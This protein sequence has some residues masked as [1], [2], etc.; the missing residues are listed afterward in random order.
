M[1]VS[2]QA[3]RPGGGVPPRRSQVAPVLGHEPHPAEERGNRDVAV[4]IHAVRNG[5]R[6]QGQQQR[7]AE[8]P[9]VDPG[10]EYVDP[11]AQAMAFDSKHDP[12]QHHSRGIG[13]LHRPREGCIG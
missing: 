3:E 7:A 5:G 4:A 6:G 1:W 9:F 11:R 13:D 12:R 8:L 10:A 2:V